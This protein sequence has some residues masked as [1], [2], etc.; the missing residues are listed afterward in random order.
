MS[1]LGLLVTL[2]ATGARGQDPAVYHVAISG[3][4]ELPTT[5]LVEQA[6]E[7]AGREG[8]AA[9]VLEIDSP[10]GRMDAAQLIAREIL[11]SS[12]PVYALVR[13][14]A[15][16]AA[17]L[18]VIAADSV[19]VLDGSSL[20]AN[21]RAEGKDDMVPAVQRALTKS[22][23]SVAAQRGLDTALAAAMVDPAIVIPRVVAADARLT[24]DGPSAV[25]LGLAAGV[26]ADL[27]DILRRIGLTDAIVH[28]LEPDWLGTTVTVANRNFRDVAIYVVRGGTQFRLG[29]VTSMNSGEWT[30]A[31]EFL[32]AGATVRIRA[33]VI[34]SS[35][36]VTTDQV[37]VRPG[38]VI[39]WSIENVLANS[40][41]F[42]FT[43]F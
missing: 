42:I 14:R 39:Q 31:P 19:F 6:V 36:R 24:V 16:G 22:F 35:D 12:V 5:R 38:L 43:R 20:G 33:E 27:D 3:P 25:R 32:R 40:S 21:P 2:T 28:T 7:T 34:G 17:A 4:I 15:W 23:R 9:V 13:D 30:L 37:V 8:A 41:F 29:T 11:A 18:P 26:V 10:G 1:T